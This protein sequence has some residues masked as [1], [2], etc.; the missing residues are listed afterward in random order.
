VSDATVLGATPPPVT[1][2]P[3]DLQNAG[4]PLAHVGARPAAGAVVE[5][6][7]SATYWIFQAGGRRALPI[8]PGAVAVNDA[9][10]AP[11][12]ILPPSSGV[13]SP[14]VVRCVVPALRRRTIPQART[15]LTRAHCRL[16]TIHRPRSRPRHTLRVVSQSA[17]AATRH[18]IAFRVSITVR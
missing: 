17:K 4:T 16:G 11:Y 3:W 15:A 2:D 14:P 18:A 1:I 10:L 5:G 8:T 9:A 6:L 12:P 13:P 7:P